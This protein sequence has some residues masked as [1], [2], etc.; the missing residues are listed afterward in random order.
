MC[1]PALVAD[2]G[3]GFDLVFAC[4]NLVDRLAGQAPMPVSTCFI[5]VAVAVSGPEFTCA[6][7]LLFPKDVRLSE[8]GSWIAIMDSGGMKGKIS[9]AR[10]LLSVLV[11]S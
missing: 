8:A 9:N 4:W 6:L 3:A 11:S 5:V 10:C 7:Y 2:R 1:L